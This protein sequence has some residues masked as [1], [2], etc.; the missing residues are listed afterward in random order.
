[1]LKRGTSN[2]IVD[3]GEESDEDGKGQSNSKKNGSKVNDET[4]G[5]LKERM[6]KMENMFTRILTTVEKI[7]NDVKHIKENQ[8]NSL[9]SIDSGRSSSL[10]VAR[11][12]S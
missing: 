5:E 9:N 11:G 1:M 3:K 6:S 8:D 2:L 4:L 12:V 10:S 7:G